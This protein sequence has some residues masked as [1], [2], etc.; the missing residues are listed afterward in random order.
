MGLT[1]A[2]TVMPVRDLDASLRFYTDVLGFRQEFR[3]DSYAGV[4]RDG[5]LIHL[6]LQGNPNTS[7]PGSGTIYIFCDDVD[8]IYRAAV[9][10]GAA[11]DGE[12]KDYPYGMRDFVALDPD[13]NKLS[14]GSPTNAGD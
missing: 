6:S 11:V 4:E 12:P 13:A 5:C 7:A 2:A 1:G 10:Q 9:E 14:F 8:S 3:F